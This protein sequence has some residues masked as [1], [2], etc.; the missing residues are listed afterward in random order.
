MQDNGKVTY[1]F[2][3]GGLFN[4]ISI[5]VTGVKAVDVITSVEED[6]NVTRD[7][8]QTPTG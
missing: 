7:R 5:C 1:C 6:M 8:I 2:G 4:V 3:A